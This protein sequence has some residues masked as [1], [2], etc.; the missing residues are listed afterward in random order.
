MGIASLI[1]SIISIGIS[2]IVTGI[3][4]YR[5]YIETKTQIALIAC[6]GII[7]DDMIHIVVT[8]V[9]RNW[10]NAVITNSHISLC[11]SKLPNGFTKANHECN[12]MV[13]NPIVLR[14]KMH[15]S[16]KLVYS[17]PDLRGVDFSD[18]N[19]YVNTEYVDSRGQIKSDSHRIGVLC[20]SGI[21][22]LM[23]LIE[24]VTYKLRGNSII[25]SMKI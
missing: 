12:C 9:N 3:P 25:M 5:K 14:E 6:N 10:Q 23:V 18:V 4:F 7:R 15:A 17:L 24:S 20:M 21:G 16:V 13:F 2:A 1:I 8:Y 11:H 19:L 22:T